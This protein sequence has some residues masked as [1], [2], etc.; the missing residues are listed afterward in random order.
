[1]L[2]YLH[3]AG[4]SPLFMRAEY[5]NKA[6]S[7]AD[8]VSEAEK[9]IIDAFRAFLMDDEIELAITIFR[10]LT[11]QFKDDH[12]L[13]GYLTIR[14]LNAERFDEALEPAELCLKRDPTFAQAHNFLGHVALGKGQYDSAEGHFRRYL[15]L[16]PHDPQPYQSLGDLYETVGKYDEAAVQ[17]ERVLE[18]SPDFNGSWI[19]HGW[20]MDV[21]GRT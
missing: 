9:R 20:M 3:R 19:R 13:P 17:Y 12:Y 11:E 14:Y 8:R 1:M 18:R 7:N 2:A 21:L 5:V 15:S 10:D 6:D 4:S 16:A